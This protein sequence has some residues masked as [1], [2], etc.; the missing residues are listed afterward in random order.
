MEVNKDQKMSIGKGYLFRACD[1]KAVN[2]QHLHLA[3]TQWQ[4]KEWEIFIVGK[5]ESFR[6]APVGDLWPGEA[7]GKLTKSRASYVI[8]LGIYL[9]FTGWL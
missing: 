6:Y 2:H 4:R 1:T 9:T 3:G 8:I 5:R 7:V